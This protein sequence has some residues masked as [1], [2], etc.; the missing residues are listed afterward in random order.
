LVAVG[1]VDRTQTYVVAVDG[2]TRYE[3]WPHA[4]PAGPNVPNVPTLHLT[5]SLASRVSTAAR[6]VTAGKPAG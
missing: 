5:G 4:S 3:D 1:M 6:G 2:Q